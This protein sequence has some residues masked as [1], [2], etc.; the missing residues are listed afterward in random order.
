MRNQELEISGVPASKIA[1]KYRTPLYV[2]DAEKIREQYRKLEEAFSSRYQNFQINYAVKANFNPE[3]SRILVEEGAGLDCASKAEMMLADKIGAD[4]IM[5]TAPYS[6]EDELSYA[7][8]HGAFV[9]LDSIFLLDKMDEVPESICFRIDP[10]IGGDD[11]SVIGAGATK[12]G[13]TEE[14]AVEAYRKAIDK[15]VEKFG[16]HMMTGSN[17][18][19]PEYFGRITEKLLEVAAKISDELSIEF[20]FVDIGGG[21]GVPYKPEEDQLD[22]EKTAEK[23]TDTFRKG[24]ERYDIGNPELRVEPGRFLVAESGHLLTRVTGKKKKKGNTYVGVDAGMHNFLRPM[25]MGTHHEIEKIGTHQSELSEKTLVGS[26]CTTVDK[27]AEKRELPELES[28]D[29]L[30]IENTG[31]YGFS[32]SASYWNGK[33]MPAEVLVENGE[34][35]LI[36][37]REEKEAIL[38]GTKLEKDENRD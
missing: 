33:P 14:K 1:E 24:V 19:D 18:R 22:I 10:G 29:I 28:D 38:H 36:R 35:R 2:Y 16:I 7:V 30:S 9:N 13:V 17:I 20:E 31:A 12:F 6:R 4:E 15:G 8:E 11:L 27:L 37:E 34:T 5:Y 32:L 3:I 23:V 25:L 26:S 21:F